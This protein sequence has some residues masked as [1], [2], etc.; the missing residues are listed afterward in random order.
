LREAVSLFGCETNSP[1]ARKGA[2]EFSF[3]VDYTPR[4]S[5]CGA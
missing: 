4:R 2:G 5:E 1:E 3:F